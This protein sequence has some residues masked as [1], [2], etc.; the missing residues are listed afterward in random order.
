MCTSYVEHFVV[1]SA[2]DDSVTKLFVVAVVGKV[3]T[4]EMVGEH[5]KVDI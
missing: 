2:A 3:T 1:T 4:T 5:F